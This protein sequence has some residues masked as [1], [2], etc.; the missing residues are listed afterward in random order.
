MFG[1]AIL[2]LIKRKSHAEINCKSVISRN[3]DSDYN[4]IKWIVY[5]DFRDWNLH[6]NWK[7]RYILN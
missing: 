2:H 4:C 6:E 1:S 7:S 5:S 3:V